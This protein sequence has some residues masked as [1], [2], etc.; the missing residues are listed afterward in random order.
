MHHDAGNSQCQLVQNILLLSLSIF[1]SVFHLLH[2]LFHIFECSDRH[3]DVLSLPF[4]L[5]QLHDESRHFGCK[6]FACT[7]LIFRSCYSAACRLHQH[8]HA[9]GCSLM[10]S[11]YRHNFWDSYELLLLLVVATT[12]YNSYVNYLVFIVRLVIIIYFEWRAA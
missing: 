5:L 7:Q 11:T 3:T 8:V 10:H 9:V 1:L 2:E 6:S 12:N 4:H